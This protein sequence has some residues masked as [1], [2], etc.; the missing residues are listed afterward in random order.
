[1][2]SFQCVPTYHSHFQFGKEVFVT[3]QH[4]SFQNTIDIEESISNLFH[5]L[6]FEMQK[7]Y[8]YIILRS[9]AAKKIHKQRWIKNK[10]RNSL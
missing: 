4:Y 6:E 3:N 5:L 9:L 8:L 1:M 7:N 2:E 10:T